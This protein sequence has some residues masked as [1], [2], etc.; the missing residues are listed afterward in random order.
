MV[1]HSNRMM[2]SSVCLFVLLAVSLQLFSCS[3]GS[4]NSS[5]LSGVVT[6]GEQRLSL[7]TVTLYRT[8]SG[9]QPKV[10]G[11]AQTDGDGMFA[12]RYKGSLNVDDVFYVIADNGSGVRFAN[13]GANS[14]IPS[15]I[16]INERTT[17]AAAY[18]M[19]QFM[20]FDDSGETVISGTWPGLQNAAA[21]AANLADPNNG[22]VAAVLGSFP[23][24][25][26]TSTL[27]T[28][29]SLANMLAACVDSEGAC[30][31]LIIY[32]TGNGAIVPDN[33]LRAVLNIVHFPW[34][35]V[36][37]LL[38]LSL[39]ASTYEP[40]LAADAQIDAWTL[41]LRYDGN[42]AELNG[43]GNIAFDEAG[44]AWICNNYLFQLDPL[45]PNGNVC[46]D[47]HV[48]RFT[49][50]GE[51]FPAAP[52][53]GGGLYGAGFG[54]GIDTNGDVWVGN[55]GFQGAN[56]SNDLEEL[57]MTV[58]AFSSDGTAISP[59]SM[60]QDPGG[61]FGAGNTIRRP[62]ATVSDREGNIWIVNCAA[63]SVTQ[64][65]GGDPD[66]AFDIFPLDDN[67]MPVLSQPFD[68]AIDPE[69]NAWITSNPN[70]RVLAVDPDGN[71]LHLLTGEDTEDALIVHPMGIAPDSQGNLWVANAGIMNPPCPDTTDNARFQ[72][73]QE[74]NS[75][76]FTNEKA[77]VTMI[78]P[79]GN[80]FGPFKGGGLIWPWGIAVDGND[81]IWVA[82]F[83][84]Q[85]V[86]ELCGVRPETCPAGLKTGDPISPDGGYSSDALVRN[87]GVQIDPSGNVWLANNWETVPVLTNP[88]G[89]EMVVFI[90]LA[91]PI[92]APLIGPPEAS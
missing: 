20:T 71:M 40:A 79:D 29:N 59:D 7:M 18:A 55:F 9:Q 25:A 46:G 38:A 84:D 81:N 1:H 11:S 15:D 78:D 80:A 4:S 72:A 69:G 89:H 5:T 45:D 86:S 27:A 60:G 6:S 65:P 56:C 21:T 34:R 10:L 50:T 44:N 24:G 63:D 47:D 37:E 35:N 62:Q 58:S 85:R 77:S 32:T 26:A 8:Q 54:I 31:S 30:T 67:D 12:I 57:S 64:F 76:G 3:S 23:N 13:V 33:T 53:R 92:K 36:K 19:A 51:D 41:A 68:I 61:F 42:G 83:H 87:T 52:Y 91:K 88:G 70:H 75:P 43:P 82:N 90:G 66:A 22:N 39:S 73:V 28:F 49:P 16:V 2:L 48:L 14:N 74:A 17:V